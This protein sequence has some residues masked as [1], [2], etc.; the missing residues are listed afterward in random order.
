MQKTA[1]DVDVY[2]LCGGLG[3]RLRKI[4]PKVPKPLVKI[5]GKSF[6]DIIINYMAN[7]GFRR[8]ILGIGYKADVVKEYYIRNPKQGLKIIFSQEKEPL[9]T[10]GAVKKAKKLI[11]SNPFF[12]LNGD[13]FCNF[14]PLDFLKFHK[15]KKSLVSILLRQVSGAKD[16]GEAKVD[17]SW[18]ILSFNEKN[19]T[20]GKSWINAGAYLFDKK[21]FNFMPVADRFSL[22][23]DFFPKIAGSN[24]FGY[25]KS[26]FFIDIG[27]P[28]R[29]W[30]AKKY[31][32]KNENSLWDN[33]NN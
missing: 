17:R 27:T 3:K 33:Q 26:G 2:I 9:G 5:G 31:L 4:S 18:R 7:F 16:Y 11:S 12:V 28:E 20:R 23:Y 19:N 15:K 25:H 14:N 10:G 24:I 13:S 29:Y 8:F 1:K 32:E 21:V 6:L 30:E 22:E